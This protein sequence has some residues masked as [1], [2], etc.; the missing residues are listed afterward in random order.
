MKSDKLKVAGLE[1]VVFNYITFRFSLKTFHYFIAFVH[2]GLLFREQLFY[3]K[4]DNTFTRAYCINK[5][6]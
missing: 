3:I 5:T 2:M 1:S 4:S 6:R